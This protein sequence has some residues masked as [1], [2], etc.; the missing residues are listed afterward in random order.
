MKYL[1]PI[2]QIG[3]V[4][5]GN[6]HPV[7]I[8]SM[9]NTVTCDAKSTAKQCEQLAKAGAEMVRVTV[10]TP[11]AALSI[12][13]LKKRLV[14]LGYSN[15]PI[16]GD[17]HFNGHELLTKYAK[18]AKALDKYRINPGNVGYGKM[19]S[20]NFSTM[21]RVAC[22]Y[23]KPVR[24]GVNW[25]SLDRE[26]VSKY[27]NENAV[28]KRPKSDREMMVEIMTESALLSALAAEKIGMPRNKI[29]LSVKMS[30]VPDM[31]SAYELLVEKMVKENRIYA[32]HLGLTEAGA[33]V[34]GIVASVSALAVLLRQG[35]GDTIRVSL[36]PEP[37]NPRSRE[38]EVCKALLQAMELRHFHPIVTSCPG[39]GRT[40]SD[41]FQTLAKKVNDFLKLKSPEWKKKGKN[42][43]KLRIAVMGC[44]VNGPG[45]AMH[46]DIGISLPGRG[47]HSAQ[48]FAKGKLIQ[49]M[50]G[51]NISKQFLE[52]LE[53]WI[54]Q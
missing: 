44:V 24:I 37:K 32:L 50:R 2:V 20:K 8:Q 18:C 33:G 54:E 45:E 1:T 29:V 16:I 28:K 36:T 4:K 42:I 14:D 40:E 30:Q 21:I 48:I 41:T 38:V 53:R 46:A 3:N 39:C 19:G 9:T 5:I 23:E 6:G 25:G 52:I 51:G 22:E 49:T 12:P 34:A 17:F 10:N 26:M 27:M 35:I 43:E 31:V 15:L 7:A 11:S 47:E 13:E